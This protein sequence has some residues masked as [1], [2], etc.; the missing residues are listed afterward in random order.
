MLASHR[1]SLVAARGHGEPAGQIAPRGMEI[2]RIKRALQRAEE[3]S[4]DVAAAIEQTL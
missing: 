1:R 4:D 3:L 2:V